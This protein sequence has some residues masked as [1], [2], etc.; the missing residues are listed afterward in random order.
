MILKFV[1]KQ[2]QLIDAM[3]EYFVYFES[4]ATNMFILKI[5]PKLL[6]ITNFPCTEV[7][8]LE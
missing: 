6:K 5:S 8:S 1:I 7:Q 3:F 2:G 4:R